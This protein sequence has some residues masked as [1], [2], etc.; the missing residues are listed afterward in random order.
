[1][2]S[3]RITAHRVS[4]NPKFLISRKRGIIPASMYMVST[5]SRVKGF[6]SIRFFLD[7]KYAP[8][9]VNTIPNPTPMT[10]YSSVFR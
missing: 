4:Y 8:R 6:F 1:M 2:R 5:R 9:Q 7:I 3:G 10:T